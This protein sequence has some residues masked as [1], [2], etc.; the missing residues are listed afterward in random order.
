VVEAW[1][2]ESRRDAPDHRD[3]EVDLSD[4]RLESIDDVAGCFELAE[5]AG[6]G[7]EIE[8]DAGEQL[9]KLIVQLAGDAR[10]LFLAHLFET[11]R[12]S[13]IEI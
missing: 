7:D 13:R 4:S 10:P 8:L 2:A 6:R 11:L 5:A 1:W 12:Q 3:T 9:A